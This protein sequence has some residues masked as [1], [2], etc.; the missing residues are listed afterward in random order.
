M[1]LASR[2]PL[3]GGAVPPCR[4]HGGR[5]RVAALAQLREIAA[6]KEVTLIMQRVCKEICVS[7]FWFGFC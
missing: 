5:F 1:P 2:C 3:G 4:R 7:G 6:E